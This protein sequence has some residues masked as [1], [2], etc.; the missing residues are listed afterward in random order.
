MKKSILVLAGA[1]FLGASSFAQTAQQQDA[2]KQAK[3]QVADHKD[4]HKD[5]KALK[6]DKTQL[7][8]DKKSGASASDMKDAKSVA[9]PKQP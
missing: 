1:L 9:K 5:S 4:K 3:E 8:S 7:K 2:K 6:S